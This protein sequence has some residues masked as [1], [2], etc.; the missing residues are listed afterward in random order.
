MSIL[1]IF[2]FRWYFGLFFFSFWGILVIFRFREYFGHFLSF[3]GI[4]VIL[5]ISGIFWSFFG[6]QKYF[7][8][9]LEI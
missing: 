7:G 3:G 5:W 6:F 4:L 2:R 8:H 1:V 9:F